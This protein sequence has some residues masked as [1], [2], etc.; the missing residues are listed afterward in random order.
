MTPSLSILL[1]KDIAVVRKDDSAHSMFKIESAGKVGRWIFVDDL[2]ASGS[3][4]RKVMFE[5]KK[6]RRHRETHK[7]VGV[8]CYDPH[9]C[10]SSSRFYTAKQFVGEFGRSDDD[11]LP[12][13]PVNPEPETPPKIVRLEQIVEMKKELVDKNIL[14]LPVMPMLPVKDPEGIVIK[15]TDP[16]ENAKF[17]F[18]YMKPMTFGTKYILPGAYC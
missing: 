3:T 6:D 11:W 17:K 14:S 10:N 8:L 18:D 9:E 13:A 16:F 12:R 15:E 2:V 1:G 5:L 4:F 7:F